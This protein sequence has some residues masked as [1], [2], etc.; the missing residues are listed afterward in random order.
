MNKSAIRQNSRFITPAGGI[1]ALLCFFLPWVKFDCSGTTVT[2]SGFEIATQG[3]LNLTTLALVAAVAI[4]GISLYMLKE[5]TPWKSRLPV[6]ISSGIGLG[7]L[8]F[9]FL[10]LNTGV[11][12]GLGK[13]SLKELEASFQFGVFGTII[14]F[15]LSIVGVWNYP[16]AGDSAESNSQL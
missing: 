7:C 5:Q 16:K 3:Q 10:R 2:L 4:I 13:I 11:D 14:G 6:L 1:V 8:F 9:G 12:T 15:I